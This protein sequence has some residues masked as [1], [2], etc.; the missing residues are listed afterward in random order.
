MD[1]LKARWVHHRGEIFRVHGATCRFGYGLTDSTA[2]HDKNRVDTQG[3]W[4]Y[5]LR[6]EYL[7]DYLLLFTDNCPRQFRQNLNWRHHLN[8]PSTS[9]CGSLHG[10]STRLFSIA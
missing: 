10:K 7:G 2:I 6:T 1:A 9:R 8:S 3:T 5:R 4:R